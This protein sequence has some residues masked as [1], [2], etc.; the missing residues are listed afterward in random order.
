M[1][2]ISARWRIRHYSWPDFKNMTSVNGVNNSN[3]ISVVWDGNAL[4]VYYSTSSI[5]QRYHVRKY[6]YNNGVF[7]ISQTLQHGLSAPRAFCHNGQYF[8][9]INADSIRMYDDWKLTNIIHIGSHSTSGV[10]GIC[11]NGEHYILS[12]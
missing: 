10:D 3:G 5:P 2:L 8:V 12:Q 7:R 4:Y 11:F 9:S 1:G 6:I